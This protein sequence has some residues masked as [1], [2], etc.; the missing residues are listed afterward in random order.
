M[1]HDKQNDA[2]TNDALQEMLAE[3]LESLTEQELLTECEE[4][5]GSIEGMVDTFKRIL[6]KAVETASHQDSDNDNRHFKSGCNVLSLPV[7]EK[8]A[9]LERVRVAHAGKLTM[10]ARN[11]DGSD[12]DIDRQLEDL[13]DLEVIDQE[14]NIL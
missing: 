10:A 9:V 5:Y 7:E 12:E 1:E 14:G 11:A 2:Q 4:D 3:D 8:R 13:I 6:G